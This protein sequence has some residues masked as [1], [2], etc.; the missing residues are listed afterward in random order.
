MNGSTGATRRTNKRT[1]AKAGWGATRIVAAMLTLGGGHDARLAVSVAILT[2]D[3]RGSKPPPADCSADCASASADGEMPTVLPMMVLLPWE[4]TP[5]APADVVLIPTLAYPTLKITPTVSPTPDRLTVK[6]IRLVRLVPLTPIVEFW[7]VVSSLD[8][9]SAN[10]MELADL[11]KLMPIVL[12]LFLTAVLM[13]V[14]TIADLLETLAETKTEV[15]YLLKRTVI[16]ETEFAPTS[17][18]PTITARPSS[19]LLI[20]ILTRVAA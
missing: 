19:A 5:S 12:L 16:P 14:A 2:N 7:M 1:H 3:G 15:K 4:P 13:E 11:A 6:P 18:L 10:P 17:V 8:N 9:L 20:V